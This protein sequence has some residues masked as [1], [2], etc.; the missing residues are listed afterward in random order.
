MCF[1][2]SKENTIKRMAEMPDEITVYKFLTD[3]FCGPHFSGYEYKPGINY[4]YR[5]GSHLSRRKRRVC[6][7]DYWRN[8]RL[9]RQ[10]ASSG[11]YVYF[12]KPKYVEPSNM[13]VRLKVKKTDLLGVNRSGNIGLFIKAE[14]TEQEYKKLLKRKKDNTKKRENRRP[15]YVRSTY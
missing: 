1:A 5:I 11:I 4:A 6:K 12:D 9:F 2:I 7:S 14:L 13:L 8:R 10:K 15:I 3:S